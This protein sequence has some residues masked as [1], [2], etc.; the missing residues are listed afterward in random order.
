M[1]D[2]ISADL[3]VEPDPATVRLLEGL[4]DDRIMRSI[5][6]GGIRAAAAAVATKARAFAPRRGG[7]LAQSI[8]V[9]TRVRGD[10]VTGFVMAGTRAQVLGG[11]RVVIRARSAR[12]TNV[13]FYA[14][15]V[16]E[17]TQPHVI[18]ASTG[19]AL[20]IG[21]QAYASVRHPGARANPFM[22][23][24]AQSGTAA[25]ATAF[26]QYVDRR[27]ERLQRTGK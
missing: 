19:K 20:G 8:R 24:A 13:A 15:F 17:G 21:G 6:R 22:A 4:A 7:E 12:R 14:R 23:R 2:F 26:D 18:R 25:A 3:R 9:R 27:I 10:D 11:G 16:E 1:A 5:R